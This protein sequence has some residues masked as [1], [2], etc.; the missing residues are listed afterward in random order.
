MRYE[1]LALAASGTSGSEAR[2]L[3]RTDRLKPELRAPE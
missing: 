3:T 2:R 1:D